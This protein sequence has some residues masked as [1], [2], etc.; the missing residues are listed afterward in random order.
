M[1]AVDYKGDIYPCVRYMESSL[2][3]DAPPLIIGNVYDG[4]VQNSLCEQCVKQLKAVNRLTQSSDEC[5]NCR[6]AEGCSWCQA[7]N[8]QDSGGDVNHR[9]TYICVM[10]QARSLANSYYYNR[11]YL[12]TN[13]K[14]RVKIWLEDDKALQIIPQEELALLKLLQYPIL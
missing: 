10:H 8:Y 7:Y 5:I 12:Q 9:A 6:I 1:I 14:K 2:G 11:Y 3:Q 4:I 13:Q